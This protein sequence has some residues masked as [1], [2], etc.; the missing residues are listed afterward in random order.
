MTCAATTAGPAEHQC[1]GIHDGGHLRFPSVAC[2]APG[3]GAELGADS[4]AGRQETIVHRCHPLAQ[5]GA[6]TTRD[7]HISTL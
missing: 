2:Q 5:R 1:T 6:E 7:I 3:I 4:G